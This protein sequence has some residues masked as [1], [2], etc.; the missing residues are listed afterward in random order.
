ML[1]CMQ[2]VLQ[3]DS[4]GLL[5]LPESNEAALATKAFENLKQKF[6]EKLIERVIFVR[7]MKVILCFNFSFPKIPIIDRAENILPFAHYMMLLWILFLL[8]VEG[9]KKKCLFTYQ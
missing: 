5:I 8:V 3:S 6:G 7:Y 2:R 9:N 1:E 4:N